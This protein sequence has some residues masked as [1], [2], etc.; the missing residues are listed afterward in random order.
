MH[1]L[2]S[3][4]T[5]FWQS[6]NAH[7]LHSPFVFDLYTTLINSDQTYY[8]FDQIE[9]Q[10]DQLLAD[11]KP[12]TML[13][14]GTGTSGTRSVAS[15][16]RRSLAPAKV[17]QLLFKLVDRF[18]AQTVV[19][20]G[21]S[22]GITS[23]YLAKAR[24]EAQVYTFEGSLALADL[25][26]QHLAEAKNIHLVRGNLDTTL[27]QTLAQLPRLDLVFLDANHRYEPTLRYTKLCLDHAHEGSI[28][29]LDDI[30]WSAEMEQAWE[31]I[32]GLPSVMLTIDLFRVG[33]VF[34]RHNQ[35]KQHFKLR[36]G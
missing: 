32:K 20:L 29:V 23:L 6:G 19:E 24:P 26:A 12:V 1:Q 7:G 28:L 22:L 10:R 17:G 5:F 36:F 9:A 14:F 3:Y 31:E 33:L 15:L 27:A 13:D 21:T 34:L 35:P 18:R 16:A 25:A 11:Q 4:L 2:I 30:H 8:A